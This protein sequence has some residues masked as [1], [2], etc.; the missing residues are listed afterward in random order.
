MVCYKLQETFADM[1]EITPIFTMSNSIELTL[2]DYELLSYTLQNKV[3]HDI[4][5]IGESMQD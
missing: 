3:T 4:R 2:P 5:W 1:M